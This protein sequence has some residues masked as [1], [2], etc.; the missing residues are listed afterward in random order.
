VSLESLPASL[1]V[2]AVESIVES[3]VPPESVGG[4]PDELD[5]EQPAASASKTEI[6][7]SVEKFQRIRRS[8]RTTAPRA[9]AS[10]TIARR[11]G[12]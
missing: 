9:R 11:Q 3:V 12:R 7:P 2:S 6:E 5:D 10:A 4:A 1:D 8:Y